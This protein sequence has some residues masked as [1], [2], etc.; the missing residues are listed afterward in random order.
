M[1]MRERSESIHARRR[2]IVHV[3]RRYDDAAAAAQQQ[4]E[5]EIELKR[6]DRHLKISA[7]VGGGAHVQIESARE[8][9]ADGPEGPCGCPRGAQLAQLELEKLR[10]VLG[11]T[12]SQSDHDDDGARLP[13]PCELT[14]DHAANEIERLNAF[15]SHRGG[16]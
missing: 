11:T 5:M 15:L 10:R 16:A 4:H 7:A 2:W 6:I 3:S 1:P 9:E 13:H 14:R 8:A 12:S